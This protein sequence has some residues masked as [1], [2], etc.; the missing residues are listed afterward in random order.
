MYRRSN[1]YSNEKVE[2][3]GYKFGSK[4]E[5]QIYSEFKL[6][7]DIKILR[8]QPKFL[9]IPGFTRYDKKI[10]PIYYVADFE[11]IQNEK[12]W[13]IDV[14]S[15]ATEKNAEYRLK[16]KLF[17]RSHLRTRFKEI[18]FGGRFPEERVW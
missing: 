11:I 17:L 3:D 2:I 4:Y 9:L 14:K 16:R 1:K 7:P 8:L 15:I 10:L 18:I 5:A 6:D 12:E 13:V